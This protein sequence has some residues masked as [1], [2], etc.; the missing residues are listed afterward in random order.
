MAK[1]KSHK[2]LNHKKTS[3]STAPSPETHTTRSSSRVTKRFTRAHLA[4]SS[5]FTPRSRS[6]GASADFSRSTSR[7]PEHRVATIVS[8]ESGAE[9][10]DKFFSDS[11]EAEN[12]FMRNEGLETTATELEVTGLKIEEI[13]KRKV[14]ALQKELSSA[15]LPSTFSA[16]L[17]T[18]EQVVDYFDDPR[19]VSLFSDYPKVTSRMLTDIQHRELNVKDIP[20]FTADFAAADA[21][22]PP[23]VKNMLQL[24]PSFEV[25]CQIVCAL[26]PCSVQIPLQ[27]AMSLYRGRLMAMSDVMVFSSILR[28]H[29]EF[30]ARAIRTG[31]D[32]PNVW[33][34][35]YQEAERKL[36]RRYRIG[37]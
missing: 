28:Y 19:F 26:A 11:E 34:R 1:D 20:R 15:P 33:R 6:R 23:E 7:A 12:V 10:S 18:T 2:K 31:L 8:D 25:F 36:Q 29:N 24:L 27:L 37:S 4:V 22:N 17:A 16:A 3:K 21:K 32:D 14:H 30:V 13:A 5:P 35:P 9:A